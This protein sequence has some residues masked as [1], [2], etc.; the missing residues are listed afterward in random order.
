MAFSTKNIC[1]DLLKVVA[2]KKEYSPNA[3]LMVIYHG[4]KQ[5][6]N[7]LG[8]RPQ[9]L[10]SHQMII[11]IFEC[12]ITSPSLKDRCK[13]HP[14]C[15]LDFLSN[16][17]SHLLCFFFWGGDPPK[18][19][20]ENL[21]SFWL[22]NSPKTRKTPTTNNTTPN[23]WH[24]PSTSLKTFPGCPDP[25]QGSGFQLWTHWPGPRGNLDFFLNAWSERWRGRLNQRL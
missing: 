11:R 13:I 24:P 4:G 12:N 3:G 15:F 16:K 20:I 19:N 17:H 7:P 1:L 10:K 21:Y 25:H 5:T 18:K 14:L 6:F 9:H 22:A 8:G 23:P 2:E